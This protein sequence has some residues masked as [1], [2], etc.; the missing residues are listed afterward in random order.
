MK[1]K[2]NSYEFTYV[3]DFLFKELDVTFPLTDFKEQMLTIK[4]VATS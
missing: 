4:N 3:H 2:S 1:P